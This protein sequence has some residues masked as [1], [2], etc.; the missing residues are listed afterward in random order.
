MS[1]TF[2]D[3]L[4]T[5]ILFSKE[6]NADLIE[7]LKSAVNKNALAICFQIG[8]KSIINNNLNISLLFSDNSIKK[9][10]EFTVEYDGIVLGRL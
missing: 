7:L 2:K 8:K 4:G 9:V 5:K 10:I 3:G 6:Q 1:S